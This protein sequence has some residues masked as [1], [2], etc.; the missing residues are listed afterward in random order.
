MH[1]FFF[2]MHTRARAVKAPRECEP[3]QLLGDF[4][5]FIPLVSLICQI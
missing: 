5:F 4:F 3:V 1:K 2:V